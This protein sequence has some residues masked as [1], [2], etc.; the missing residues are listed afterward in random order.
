MP[1]EETLAEGLC[2]ER[3]RYLRI[4]MNQYRFD[5]GTAEDVYSEVMMAMLRRKASIR[6]FAG[7]L[8][9]TVRNRS[10]NWIKSHRREIPSGHGAELERGFRPLKTHRPGPL[11][12]E[13]LEKLPDERDRT[14][15]RMRAQGLPFK[16]IA[17]ELSM[18]PGS[19]RRQ[20][21]EAVD[22]LRKYRVS[23]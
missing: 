4:M 16:A 18:K 12:D 14:I 15:L 20:S 23:A 7:Y 8:R 5:Y 1:Y 2:A 9:A 3:D 13:L 17:A 21:S 11:L 19:V 6:D 22:W 10:L